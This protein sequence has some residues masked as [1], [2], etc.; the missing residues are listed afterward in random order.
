[1]AKVYFRHLRKLK[2]CTPRIKQWC[3]DNDIP[4]K[5]FR[6]GIDSDELRK[7]GCGLAIKAA[8]LA[9]AESRLIE[10]VD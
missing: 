1:M 9:D 6:E 5:S 10:R 4:L 7:T 2:Y 3:V 8:D